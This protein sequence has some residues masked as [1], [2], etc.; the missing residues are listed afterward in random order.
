MQPPRNEQGLAPVR[1]VEGELVTAEAYNTQVAQWRADGFN[2]LTPSVA[3]STIPRDHRIV[4]SRVALNPNPAAGEVY[5]NSLFT[6]QGEVA[7]S[8]VGLEK[9]AQCAGISIEKVVRVDSGT[10]PYLWSFQAYGWWIGFDGAR[11]DRVKGRTLDLRDG[12][13][14]LK[15]FSAN[16]I[17]QARVHGEAVC[18]SKAI[19]RVYR[20]YGV[21]QKYLQAELDRPFIVCKLRYE[22]DMTNPIVAAIVTQI[23]MGAT[24]LLFPQAIDLANVNPL[25]LPEHVRPSAGP[26]QADTTDRDDDDD[27]T[28]VTV[29]TQGAPTKGAPAQ[30]QDFDESAPAA[31]VDADAHEQVLVTHVGQNASRTDFWI[32]LDDGRVLHTS[33]LTMAKAC[34]AAQKSKTRI[35]VTIERKGDTLELVELGGGQY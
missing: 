24:Q 21:K 27:D 32:T 35:A 29:A 5:Q 4:V 22:P 18:E 16:Q 25:Q 13:D 26:P 3:L 30:I 14:A 6:K 8:K 31:A 34:A 2:V 12:S 10:V 9:I 1:V 17:A 7:L 23:R 33:E 15:G 11:I 28:P 19:N 20:S